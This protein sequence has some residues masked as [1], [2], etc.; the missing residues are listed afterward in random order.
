MNT[1]DGN[2][3]GICDVRNALNDDEAECKSHMHHGYVWQRLPNSDGPFGILAGISVED[4]EWR[5]LEMRDPANLVKSWR[6]W[7]RMV[8][9]CDTW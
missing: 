8:R 7:T 4:Q 2:A 3:F 9:E 1:D 6:K 5:N